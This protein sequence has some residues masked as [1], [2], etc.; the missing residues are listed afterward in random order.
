MPILEFFNFCWPKG[1]KPQNS[2][3]ASVGKI[4]SVRYWWGAQWNGISHRFLAPEHNSVEILTKKSKILP[5]PVLLRFVVL[6]S[7]KI[8]L[9][10]ACDNLSK[11]R[12]NS[13]WRI[14]F[15]KCGKNRWIKN[16]R[17]C[18][19]FLIHKYSYFLGKICDWK[20]I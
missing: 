20:K 2:V 15:Q 5:Q 11:W 18:K 13:R 6:N 9:K 17:F 1:H 8:L 19:L 10:T 4:D 12:H 3:R 16:F 14:Y 7:T